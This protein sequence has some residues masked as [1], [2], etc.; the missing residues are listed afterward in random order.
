M[1]ADYSRFTK[2]DFMQDDVFVHG[3]KYPNQVSIAFWKKYVAS[4]PGNIDEYKQARYELEF[5]LANSIRIQPPQGLKA[6]IFEE[7][8]R[9]IPVQLNDYRR[10]RRLKMWSFAACTILALLVCGLFA[11]RQ[12]YRQNL[13]VTTAYNTVRELKLPDSSRII[14]N[15]NSHI[16]YLA[17]WKAN[18]PREVWLTGEAYFEVK[19]NNI[20]P[21]NISAHERFIV[22]APKMDIQ[23]L[24]TIFNVKARPGNNTVALL[25][26]KVAVRLAGQ[27]QWRTL[28]PGKA[29]SYALQSR[30]QSIKTIDPA[31]LTAWKDRSVILPSNTRFADIIPALEENYGVHIELSTKGIAEKAIEGTLPLTDQQNLFFILSNVLKV[32][33]SEE[34]GI[35]TFTS[36]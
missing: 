14:L 8:M 2:A 20:N 13:S 17:H 10:N 31:V 24:G 25:S 6:L 26:G 34:D 36:R 4:N 1:Q 32:D 15:A 5:I 29:L 33:I 28:T 16:R 35:W 21:S 11:Y 19:H 9:G 7:V 30:E 23:V 18:Q 27:D 3:V 22:H 12:Y